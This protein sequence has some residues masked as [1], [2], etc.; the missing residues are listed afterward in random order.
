M[1]ADEL[2]EMGERG[3][4]FYEMFPGTAVSDDWRRHSPWQ[5]D[6]DATAGSWRV[7]DGPPDA[8]LKPRATA[9]SH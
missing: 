6:D 7:P 2:A 5:H 9:E 1:T 3:R 8:G 4:V